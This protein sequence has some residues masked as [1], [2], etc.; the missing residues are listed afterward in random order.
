MASERNQIITFGTY[1]RQYWGDCGNEDFPT[2]NQKNR[3]FIAFCIDFGRSDRP[4]LLLLD[5]FLKVVI[6]F[7][8]IAKFWLV[9]KI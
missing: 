8:K 7:F 4:D 9:I 2:Q 1:W 6:I 5:E 3:V